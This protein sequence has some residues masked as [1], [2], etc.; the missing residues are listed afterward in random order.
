MLSYLSLSKSIVI[1][2]PVF[3][4]YINPSNTLSVVVSIKIQALIIDYLMENL[5]FWLVIIYKSVNLWQ[6]SVYNPV[7]W[8]ANVISFV[9]VD[10]N[11]KQTLVSPRVDKET[12]WNPRTGNPSV[13]VPVHFVAF[14][15]RKHR[16][17]NCAREVMSDQEFILSVELHCRK[18]INCVGAKCWTVIQG[19]LNSEEVSSEHVIPTL[20][21]ISIRFSD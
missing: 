14:G 13:V 9:V 12:I 4:V 2:P 5:R 17:I 18:S 10:I 7:L 19:V 21:F 20:H 16:Q 15:D 3:N 11:A 8:C 1:I 6:C